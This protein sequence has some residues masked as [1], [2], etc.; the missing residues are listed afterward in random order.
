M[1]NTKYFEMKIILE[2]LDFRTRK[3]I[4]SDLSPAHSIVQQN[5]R[6]R[7]NSVASHPPA[8]EIRAL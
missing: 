1:Q 3:A 2:S 4:Q 5:S 7:G 8:P 6:E